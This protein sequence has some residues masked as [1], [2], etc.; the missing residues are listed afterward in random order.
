[1]PLTVYGTTATRVNVS[2]NGIVALGALTTAYANAALPQYAIAPIAV[3]PCW[4]DLQISPNVPQGIFYAVDDGDVGYR[5][6]TFEFYESQYNNA[7]FYYHFMLSF[8]ENLPNVVTIAYL[9]MTNSGSGATSGI[10][11]R[12]AA[13]YAQLSYNQPVL[14]SGRIVSFNFTSNT[15]YNGFPPSISAVPGALYW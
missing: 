11:S 6:T 1:M 12:T 15:W 14:T 2:T 7:S 9:N 8:Y 4:D 13:K 5:G 10:G 3:F